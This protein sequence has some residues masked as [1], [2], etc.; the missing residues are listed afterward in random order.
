LAREA[1]L[2]AMAL[3]ANSEQRD[4]DAAEVGLKARHLRCQAIATRLPMPAVA[5]V[6][7]SGTVHEATDSVDEGLALV[8]RWEQ[9]GITRF[10]GIAYDLFRFGVRVYDRYQPQFLDEFIQ[11]HSDPRRSSAAYVE[12]AEM[13]AAVQEAVDLSS[14]AGRST[15]IVPPPPVRVP[16]EDPL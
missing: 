9:Q 13:R 10:R 3:V 8:R 1:A 7:M 4:P 6:A 11:E 5:G 15:R 2:R 12:S 16:G 14:R